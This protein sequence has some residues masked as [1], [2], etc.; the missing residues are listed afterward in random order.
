VRHYHYEKT[1]EAEL[2]EKRKVRATIKENLLVSPSIVFFLI[3]SSQPTIAVWSFQRGIFEQA[4]HDAWL[5]V[6]ITGLS[7]H[8][9]IWLLYKILHRADNDIIE[10]HRKLFGKWIGGFLSIS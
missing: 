6:L 8:V 7:I 10:V 9:I 4:G 2:G 1:S 3:Y 5:V